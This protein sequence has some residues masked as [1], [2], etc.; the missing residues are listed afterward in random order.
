M[1][2]TLELVFDNNFTL[3]LTAIVA[4]CSFNFGIENRYQ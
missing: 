4:A 1:F 2:L 3:I